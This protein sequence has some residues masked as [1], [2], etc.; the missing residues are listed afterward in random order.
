VGFVVQYIHNFLASRTKTPIYVGLMGFFFLKLPILGGFVDFIWNV[1]WI[2]VLVIV[3]AGIESRQIFKG[4]I[5]H[6]KNNS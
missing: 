5:G 3:F 4:A 1:G 6:N 2:F